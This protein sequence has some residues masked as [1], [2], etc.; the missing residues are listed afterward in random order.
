MARIMLRCVLRGVREQMCKRQLLRKQQQQSQG[1]MQENAS[2]SQ[3][4]DVPW[5]GRVQ[6]P[7]WKRLHC[8]PNYCRASS[9]EI[10]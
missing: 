1:R 10:H 8:R 3:H 7:G 2:H 5:G 9:H 4:Y 6:L